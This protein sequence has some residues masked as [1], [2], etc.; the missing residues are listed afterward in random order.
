MAQGPRLPG[1]AP[2]FEFGDD[3]IAAFGAGD[4]K[5][6]RDDHPVRGTR[7]IV[8][9][10]PAVHFPVTAAFEESGPADS[11]L[12]PAGRSREADTGC[13][14]HLLPPRSYELAR[15]RAERPPS[16][17]RAPVAFARR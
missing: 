7:E 1:H 16:L 3:V 13:L 15:G 6:L 8:L 17:G 11:F 5:R 14:S 9:E 12:T 10:G 4:A 2:T